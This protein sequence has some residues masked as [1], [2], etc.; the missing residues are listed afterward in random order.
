MKTENKNKVL[1]LFL[2]LLCGLVYALGS[3]TGDNDFTGSDDLSL[4]MQIPM[5]R[6]TNPE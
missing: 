4:S 1:F 5:T 2:S 6:S 3:C